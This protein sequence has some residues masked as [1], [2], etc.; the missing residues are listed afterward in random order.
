MD[1][2]LRES[3]RLNDT[4]R[5]FLAY[6]R[7]QR[8]RRSRASTCGRVL[9]DTAMLL[10]NSPEVRDR[11]TDRRR[12]AATRGLVSRPTRARSGRSSGTSPPTACGRCPTAAGCVC[13]RARRRRTARRASC[14]DGRR[15]G[16]RHPARGARRASSSRS[17]AV[18]QG[19]RPRPRHRPPH[20]HRLRRRDRG[21]ARRRAA[22]TTRLPVRAA[23]AGRERSSRHE[24]DS[25]RAPSRPDRAT[26]RP[27]DARRA[28]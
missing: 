15:R 12:R 14:I 17:A 23:G 21:R 18:R 1:I 3:E 10:R 7:P 24:R 16:R 27:C 11:H 8:V 26:R 6:A 4:I 25:D 28:S 20:R 2:V 22:G 19:H 13:A 9:S 5:S